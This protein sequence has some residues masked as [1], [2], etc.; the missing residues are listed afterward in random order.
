MPQAFHTPSG[1]STDTGS[2]AQP[3][4]ATDDTSP[5]NDANASPAAELA[6]ATRRGRHRADGLVR[7]RSQSRR[8]DMAFPGLVAVGLFVLAAMLAFGAWDEKT[9]NEA[10]WDRGVTTTG[11]VVGFTGGRV[12]EVEAEFTTQDGT[13]VTRAIDYTGS[14]AEGDPIEVLYDP[15]NPLNVAETE[16]G[17]DYFGA[18]MFGLGSAGSAGYGMVMTWTWAGNRLRARRNQDAA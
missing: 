16:W 12:Q 8:E 14:Y 11:T 9:D 2:T 5:V 3:A 7:Y 1:V 10:L 4:A 18:V 17:P 15:Q 13:T 6:V